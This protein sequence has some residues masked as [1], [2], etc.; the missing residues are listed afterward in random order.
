MLLG[1]QQPLQSGHPQAMAL[2]NTVT[3]ETGVLKR[4]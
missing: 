4:K 3:R 2:G 1:S